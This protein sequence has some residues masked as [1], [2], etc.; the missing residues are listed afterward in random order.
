MLLA[1]ALLLAAACAAGP[2]APSS[3]NSHLIA[4]VSSMFHVKQD[5][6]LDLAAAATAT[7]AAPSLMRAELQND[8]FSQGAERVW[9]A[10][11]EYVTAIELD[12]ADP[13]AA[14][15]LVDFEIGQLTQG[16]GAVTYTP[17]K[18][19]GAKAFSF[20]GTTRA[21][22]KTIFCQGVWLAVKSSAY[23]VMD[24]D[25]QPRAANLVLDLAQRQAAQA[26][27]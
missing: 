18:P 8:G 20:Y 14:Q 5:L 25:P 1:G 6:Q 23:E 15:H 11:S 13:G 24:C 26:A 22:A 4:N 9:T 3:T 7:P 19:K 27:R 10:G 12:V 2:I 16:K 17:D 21:G